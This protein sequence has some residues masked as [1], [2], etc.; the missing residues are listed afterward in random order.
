MK[1]ECLPIV[2]GKPSQG[3]FQVDSLDVVAIGAGALEDLGD[4]GGAEPLVPS[5][6]SALVDDDGQKPGPDGI[7][8]SQ[9]AELAP[10][11]G[12]R[13]LRASQPPSGAQHRIGQAKR[14]FDGGRSGPRRPS[15]PFT[16]RS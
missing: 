12:D 10:R 3:A 2:A 4:P 7:P 15:S 13:L 1:E 8:G 14:R 9:L 16:A 11:A 5:Y 6:V